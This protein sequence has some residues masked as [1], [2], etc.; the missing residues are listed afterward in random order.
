MA[1][2]NKTTLIYVLLLALLPQAEAIGVEGVIG[3]I[4]AVAAVVICCCCVPCYVAVASV[5]ACVHAI[6]A[7]VVCCAAANDGDV[8]AANNGD[9]S[10]SNNAGFTGAYVIE[11][12]HT[13]EYSI[14]QCEHRVNT[15]SLTAP[16]AYEDIEHDRKLEAFHG[17]Y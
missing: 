5:S 10:A 1:G 12:P 2:I 4:F 8:S 7:A 9:V 3:L 17:I 13:P 11:I 15:L 14:S 16:P 6:Y